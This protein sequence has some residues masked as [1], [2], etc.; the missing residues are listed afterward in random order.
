MLYI[1]P[2]IKRMFKGLVPSVCALDLMEPF[3]MKTKVSLQGGKSSSASRTAISD[4]PPRARAEPLPRDAAFPIRRFCCCSPRPHSPPP[5]LREQPTQTIFA[6]GSLLPHLSHPTAPIPLISL[7]SLHPSS[8]IKVRSSN[9]DRPEV[10][11][12]NC[13][14]SNCSRADK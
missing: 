1:P 10:P 8:V 11:S 2:G 9:G 13:L 7:L 6:R 5:W 14:E 4:C 12:G 3:G